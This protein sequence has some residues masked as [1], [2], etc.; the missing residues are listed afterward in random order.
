MSGDFDAMA[1]EYHRNPKPGKLG[2]VATK[3]MANQRDLALAYSPGVA[4]ASTAIADDPTQAAELTARANLVAVVTNGTAV[5]GLGD[6]GPLAAKPVMEGKA[7]LFKKFA[8]ID[9]FDIELN[10]KD[11]DGLVDTIVRLEPTF[12]AINLEDIAAPACFEI[13]RRCRERMKI[14]VFHD[15]QHG[16]AIV[17]GAAVL[18][19]LALVGKDI[20]TVKVV[21]TGGG[22]AGIACLDL[23]V[24]LG[25]RRENV[26]LVDRVGVV[27]KGRNEEMNPYKD[28]YA[29]ET[30]ARVLA[31]VIDGADIFLGLSGPKVLKPELLARMADKPLILALA[32]P[33]PEIM[34][35]LAREARPDAIIA[36]GRSDFPNQV[37]NVLCFPFIFRG[38]L[39]VGATTVNEEMK[40]AATHAVAS[41]A[42]AEP[43]DVVAAAYVGES[44]RFGPDYIL[45]KPFD[46][47]LIIEVSSAVAKAAME[48]GVATRP[49]VDFRAYRDQLGQYVIRSG[50]FMKP[51]ITKAKTAPKRVV[52]AE[53]E[54]PRVIRCAQVVVDDGIAQPVLIGRREVIERTIAEMGL[55]LKVGQDVE[56]I[57]I[58]RDLRYHNYAEIY[59][60][61]MGR[62]GV[63]PAHAANVVR[64]QPIV[65]GAL[66]VRRGEADAMVCGIAGRYGDHF[67]HIMDIIGLRKGVKV[68]AAMNAL[69]SQ[70]GVHFIADTY[71]N[72]DPTAEQVA[73]IARLAA[74]EV[75]RFGIEPKVALL[76]HSNFGSADTPSARKMRTAYALA[77]AEMPDLEIDGEMHADAALSEPIRKGVLPDSR[78]K[79][80]ANLLVMPT[81]DAANIAFNMMKILGDAQN[82]GPMLLGV[83]RPVHIVTPSV[84]TR[85]LVNMTAV[86]V[87]DAQLAAPVNGAPRP[88]VPA[89]ED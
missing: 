34:P 65:F 18:N 68:A 45:P 43:S 57:E 87:V 30:E 79:G 74:E 42:R 67:G 69:I 86:A 1:L 44:L 52:Y 71:V 61:I 31:D 48:S 54:D 82:V 75:R 46:P 51:V 78:L 88:P 3:P 60:Q 25:I 49:I 83:A 35:D 55:R 27:H 4:V 19:G 36:T 14:P 89:G 9:C 47:R 22:A 66:M 16:T 80:E 11:V 20:G 76:S 58:I 33:E 29:Q 81:L 8:G 64:T 63:S 39:D 56:V 70:R 2:I 73:E 7:V 37:N 5:L 41:L 26:W 72:V 10:E 38:A 40:I 62:R 85:G 6:I 12:G 50:L 32:N 15:D 17:V 13:E 23:L 21:S 24:G 28:A 84:T 53:G 59:R 77:T